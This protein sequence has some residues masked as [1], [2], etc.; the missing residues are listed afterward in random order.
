MDVFV[1]IS[2]LIMASLILYRPIQALIRAR[3]HGVKISFYDASLMGIRNTASPELF[4]AMAAAE[5]HNIDL[6]LSDLEVHLLAGGSPSRVIE[7]LIKYKDYSEITPKQVIA[8]DLSSM[9]FDTYASK[10]VKTHKVS[11]QKQGFSIFEIDYKAVFKL[12]SESLLLNSESDA[13][14]DL[15]QHRLQELSRSWGSK[16]R[17]YTENFLKTQVFNDFFWDQEIKARLI[18]QELTVYE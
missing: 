13:A 18:Y 15:I 7:T 1:A 4:Q 2:F 3:K 9:D 16:D 10:L 8:Y 14:T 5:K 6:N 11:I 17:Q 12:S